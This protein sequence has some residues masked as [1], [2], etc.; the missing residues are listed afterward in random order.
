MSC[1]YLARLLSSADTTL[2]YLHSLVNV[3]FLGLLYSG[4]HGVLAHWHLLSLIVT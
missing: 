1:G 3:S 2:L 4:F